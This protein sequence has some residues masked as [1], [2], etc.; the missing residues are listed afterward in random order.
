MQGKTEDLK[1]GKEVGQ[2]P[3]FKEIVK[4]L[5]ENMVKDE[6]GVSRD[7]CGA[8]ADCVHPLNSRSPQIT[9]GDYK[10][11]NLVSQASDAAFTRSRCSSF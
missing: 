2:I 4:W 9:H 1:T 11:D 8:G 10:I 5:A 7:R 3:G 6:N